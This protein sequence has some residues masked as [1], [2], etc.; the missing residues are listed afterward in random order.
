MSRHKIE[1]FGELADEA[2]SKLRKGQQIAL[3]G[4]LRVCSVAY[5]VQSFS[6]TT[7]VSQMD[8]LLVRVV[9]HYVGRWFHSAGFTVQVRK[10]VSTEGCQGP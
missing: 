5:G 7:G 2:A 3:H 9:C 8:N 1:L 10:H 6:V 4:R